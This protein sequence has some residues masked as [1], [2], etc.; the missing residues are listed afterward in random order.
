MW[1][2]IR[3]WQLMKMSESA[4]ALTCLIFIRDEESSHPCPYFWS[5][6]S[7]A[8]ALVS[9]MGSKDCAVWVRDS[10]REGPKN[11]REVPSSWNNKIRRAARFCSNDQWWI[12]HLSPLSNPNLVYT[13]LSSNFHSQVP[14]NSPHF[15]SGLPTI[16]SS[17]NSQ[18]ITC[19]NHTSDCH[20]IL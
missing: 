3:K 12:T 17:P 9:L 14:P 13:I 4:W 15:L 19:W 1:G 18:S 10:Q 5:W 16:S 20:S 7:W 2:K 8:P 6:T 11:L